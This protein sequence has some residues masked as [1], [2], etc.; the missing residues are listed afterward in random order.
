VAAKYDAQVVDLFLPFAAAANTLV[1]ADCTHPS[2]TGHQVISV[3][4]SAAFLAA[5]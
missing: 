4:S 1:A 2:G 3:L 5:Q